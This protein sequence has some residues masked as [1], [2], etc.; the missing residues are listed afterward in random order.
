MLLRPRLRLQARFQNRVI[1]RSAEVLRPL[2]LQ[3]L[4]L[5]SLRTA[6]SD[7]KAQAYFLQ[8]IL[9]A[10]RESLIFR[11][12]YYLVSICKIENSSANIQKRRAG[13]VLR[14]GFFI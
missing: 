13:F 1:N 12:K 10:E 4:A 7:S 14:P 3:L 8:E 2:Q 5:A 11:K 6:S 9:K